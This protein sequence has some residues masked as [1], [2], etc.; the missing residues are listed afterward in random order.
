MMESS[1][2]YV[3]LPSNAS[4]DIYPTNTQASY[5][6]RLPRTM[7]LK[8]GFEVALVEIQ[9]PLSWDTFAV[10]SSRELLVTVRSKNELYKV[11]FPGGHY[12]NIQELI[13]A[14][15]RSLKKY[16]KSFGMEGK[17]VV[18]TQDRLEHRI[19]VYTKDNIYVKFS[20]E[21][22][23]IL[24]LLCGIWYSG[25][26]TAPF[27]HDI[28]KGFHSLFVYC[29]LCEPQ[30]V[31][32]VYAPLLRSVAIKGSRGEHVTKTY[33]EPHYLPVST[34]TVDMIEINIKDDTGHD[35]P[36]TSGKVVCKLHFRNRAL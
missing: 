26:A 21:C 13:D 33:G 7:Y 32:D 5:K 27:K 25:D 23:D 6:I 14:I 9:Y 12:E 15:N 2:F 10:Q 34:D 17:E 22:C 30:I 29:N 18:I 36:F 4:M 24:G 20:D 19:K 1:G 8:R 35:V 16:L 11:T 31:G 3:T 28:T